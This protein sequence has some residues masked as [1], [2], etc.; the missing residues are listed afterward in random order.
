MARGLGVVMQAIQRHGNPNAPL[1]SGPP[2]F[3]FSDAAESVRT[4]EAA[5]F[6]SPQVTTVPQ[7]WWLDSPDQLFEFMLR[8]TVRTG[9]LLRA[10]TPAALDAIKADVRQ[11]ALSCR[12]ADGKI[13]VPMPAVLSSAT[14]GS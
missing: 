7:T 14:K 12:R 9:A 3:R 1:P 2:F 8:S 6:V 10:Q 13:W 11:G 4:L 5:G